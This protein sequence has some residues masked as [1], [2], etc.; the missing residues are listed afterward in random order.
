MLGALLS[1]LGIGVLAAAQVGPIWLLCVRTSARYGF[2]PGAAIGVAASSVDL[3]YSLLGALGAAALLQFAPLR[4]GLGLLGG[5]VLVFLGA[6][7][8]RDA[9]RIR[10]GA[11]DEG[12]VVEPRKALRTGLIATASN[13]LTILTWGAVFSGAAVADVAGTPAS[14]LAFV[15]GIGLGS[16]LLHL[17]LAGVAAALGGR[18]GATALRWTDALSGLGLIGFGALISVRTVQEA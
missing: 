1:G 10:A 11:E 12:E 13:P 2:R 8:L 7:T 16:L 14:A 4:I 9:W 5:G 17:T 18:M 6:R 15:L 3:V